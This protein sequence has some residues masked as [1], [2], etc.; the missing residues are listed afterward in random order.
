MNQ[1]WKNMYRKIA[2]VN[3]RVEDSV[4]GV[5]VVQSLQMKNLKSH[6]SNMI[7]GNLD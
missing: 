1:A 2:D 6:V 4:S 5:R 7:M 3:G